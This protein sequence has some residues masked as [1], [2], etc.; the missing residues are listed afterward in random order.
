MR[1]R[2]LVALAGILTVSMPI[3]HASATGVGELD[4]AVDGDLGTFPC[5]GGCYTPF[6]GTGTGSGQAEATIAG[7]TYEAVFTILAGTVTGSANYAEP[8]FPFC[9]LI[10]SAT[11]P[12]T[13]TVTLSGG[14]TGVIYRSSSPTFT[15]TVTG[16]SVTLGYTYQ[17][18]A[19]AAAIV[20]TGGSVTVNYFFPGSGSG[21]F[22]DPIVAG[23]G[24]GVFQ[25]DPVEAEALCTNP[26][27]LHFTLDG[28]AVVVSS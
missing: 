8:G 12:S 16:V 13:G 2:I 7:N 14:S 24:G 20:L 9:P 10:G 4:F 6:S 11:N 18:V 15:G 19:A 23:G 27:T 17:R 22:T 5:P 21:S 1:W 26:G 3:S 25:V 28:E